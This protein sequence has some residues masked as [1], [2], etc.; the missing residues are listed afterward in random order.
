MNIL[1]VNSFNYD[2]D[3]PDLEDNF[4][5]EEKDEIDIVQNSVPISDD[6]VSNEVKNTMRKEPI[7]IPL[8]TH[9]M[10][11]IESFT[12]KNQDLIIDEEETKQ[13]Q[14]N[15]NREDSG[16]IIEWYEK[17]FENTAEGVEKAW[18]DAKRKVGAD[19]SGFA[20]DGKLTH[21]TQIVVDR[22][23]GKSE[24]LKDILGDTV[25]SA[26]HYAKY[27]Y[28]KIGE[29]LLVGNKPNKEAEEL[30]RQEQEFYKEFINNLEA[31]RNKK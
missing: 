8:Y 17:L 16:H 9:R 14:I 6:G 20:A 21:I 2:Y 27:A 13:C 25:E 31:I 18:N 15:E 5:L 10:S 26:Y 30:T 11:L 29:E 22:L 23:M 7:V 24:D 1:P 28:E 19:G 4:V 3:L 12:K